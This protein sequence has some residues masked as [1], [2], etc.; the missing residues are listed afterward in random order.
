M[1]ERRG[2]RYGVG[3]VHSLFS[4]ARNSPDRKY[5]AKH[6]A[7]V[8]RIGHTRT[9]GIVFQKLTSFILEGKRHA[10]AGRAAQKSRQQ[11]PPG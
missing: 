9:T 6:V 8:S 2:R 3:H 11:Q 4:R 5:F 7:V 10:L 1:T